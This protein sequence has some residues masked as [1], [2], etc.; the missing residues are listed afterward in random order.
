MVMS[1]DGFIAKEDGTVDWLSASNEYADGKTLTSEDIDAFLDKIDCYL[2]GSHTYEHALD[3]GWPYGDKPV[4][5]LTNRSLETDR[6]NVVFYSGDINNLVE[7]ELKAKYSNV[8]MGGG[9]EVTK[10]LINKGLADELIVSIV[11]VILGGGTPFFSSIGKEY[12][13]VLENV[14]AY[15]QGMVE[16]TYSFA[17]K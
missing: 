13:L 10:A 2:L 3:L 7:N 4:I 12:P 9:A 5:V 16:L 6:K 15:D 14:V 11:P 8:W 17:K 1:L